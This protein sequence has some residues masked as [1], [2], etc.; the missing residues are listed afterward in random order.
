MKKAAAALGNDHCYLIGKRHVVSERGAPEVELEVSSDPEARARPAAPSVLAKLPPPGRAGSL[1]EKTYLR[2]AQDNAP[3]RA[4]APRE[5][6]SAPLAGD[7]LRRMEELERRVVEETARAASASREHFMDLLSLGAK[8]A[9]PPVGPELLEG[10]RRLVARA[11][12]EKLA[13]ALVEETERARPGM[14]PEAARE[15][16]MAAMARRLGTTGPMTLREDRRPTV[17]AFVGTTGVGKTTTVGKL[18]IEFSVARGRRVAILN[19]D[20][21]RPGAEAQL[22]SF[23]QLLRNVT[24]DSA[25]TPERARHL[26]ETYADR[27][28]LLVDT[29]GRSPRDEQGIASLAAFLD[30]LRPDEVHLVIPADA[31]ERSARDAVKAFLPLRYDRLLFTK[32]DEVTEHGMLLNLAADAPQGMSYLG[33]G[34]DF[35]GTLPEAEPALMASLV[36]GLSEVRSDGAVAVCAAR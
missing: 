34:Q 2:Q 30:V 24:V 31:S 3:L 33:T 4:E 16:L 20:M 35:L 21:R 23:N 13:R 32:L 25:D 18:A 7:W 10:Y 14:G 6:A 11:V 19:E 5:S 28:V 9:L 26:L 22:R 17:A 27:D 12:E 8:G 36:M 1:F 15:A 29:G